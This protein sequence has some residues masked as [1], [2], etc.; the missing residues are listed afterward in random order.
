M[1]DA[2]SYRR[3]YYVLTVLFTLSACVAYMNLD[4]DSGHLM[5]AFTGSL[6]LS[7]LWCFITVLIQQYG[8]RIIRFFETI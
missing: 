1:D 5:V 3:T 4:D 2:L 8:R 7:A 6:G